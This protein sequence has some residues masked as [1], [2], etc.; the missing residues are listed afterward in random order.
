MTDGHVLPFPSAL[1]LDTSFLRTIGGT[2]S[3]PYQ[4][5]VQYVRDNGVELYL[6][7][8]VVEELTEQQGY[9][10]IDWIDRAETTAWISIVDSIQPGVRVHGDILP[11]VNGG[12]SPTRGI[13][14]GRFQSE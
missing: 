1:V 9:L 6:S 3:D 8:R 13:R 11:A 5:F 7:G 2:D 12:A 4:S 14:A 10:S